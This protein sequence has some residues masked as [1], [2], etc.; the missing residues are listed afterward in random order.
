[1]RKIEKEEELISDDDPDKKVFHL[2]IVNLVIGALYCAKGNYDFGIPHVIKILE[3]Y[4]TKLGTETWFYAKLCFLSLL[5]NMYKH[6]VMLKGRC[7]T[8]V[9]SVPGALRGVR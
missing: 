9:Y 4:N 3:P 5:E 8:G 1:M 2:C 7:G 6:M